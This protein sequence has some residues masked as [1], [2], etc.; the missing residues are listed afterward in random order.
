MN[1]NIFDKPDERDIG[2][3]VI[4][5]SDVYI[6]L[7]KS[8][9]VKFKVSPFTERTV[10]IY[11]F[12]SGREY[13]ITVLGAKSKNVIIECKKFLTFA[14][15]TVENIDEYT[16]RIKTPLSS[17]EETKKRH[18]TFNVWEGV[19]LNIKNL[20]LNKCAISVHC[21][22]PPFG[23]NGG[24]WSSREGDSVFEMH[25]EILTKELL[26]EPSPATNNNYRQ[27]CLVNKMLTINNA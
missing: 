4:D 5:V 15:S 27:N 13:V 19:F 22:L 23:L 1:E 2:D 25:T 21:V 17:A 14:T 8:K 3:D 7:K 6:N 26:Q 24:Q 16:F 12:A 9:S 10:E 20:S 11:N 18:K